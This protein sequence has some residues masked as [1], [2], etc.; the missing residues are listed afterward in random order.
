M[1]GASTMAHLRAKAAVIA[2]RYGYNRLYFRTS[3]RTRKR[4][5]NFMHHDGVVRVVSDEVVLDVTTRL[6]LFFGVNATSKRRPKAISILSIFCYL[7]DIILWL[8]TF[9]DIAVWTRC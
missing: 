7:I 5:R 9:G 1:D 2:E 3:S 4:R 6:K 8:A